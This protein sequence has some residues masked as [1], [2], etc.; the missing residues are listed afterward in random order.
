MIPYGVKISM[1]TYGRILHRVRGAD[2]AERRGRKDGV[3]VQATRTYMGAILAIW[4]V[5]DP[6]GRYNR[7]PNECLK[8][9]YGD[10][11]H[12]RQRGPRGPRR[13]HSTT[14][15]ARGRSPDRKNLSPRCSGGPQPARRARASGAPRGRARTA[16]HVEPRAPG[17]PRGR[18]PRR[19]AGRAA[20]P[21][22]RPGGRLEDSGRPRFDL[23]VGGAR[24]RWYTER[25]RR[26]RRPA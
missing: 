4:L 18:G 6:Y 25:Y 10:L 1:I 3:V 14:D 21:H 2:R 24:G 17:S 13:H 7:H 26:V 23:W 20:T 16:I 5:I 8:A 22:P 9:L 11:P 19:H 12:P 15:R